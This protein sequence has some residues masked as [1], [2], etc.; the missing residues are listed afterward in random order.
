M[1]HVTSSVTELPVS[2]KSAAE[3]AAAFLKAEDSY[4]ELSESGR[5][6]LTSLEKELSKETGTPVALIAYR[7]S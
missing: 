4:A 5:K 2:C 6:K 7:L 3:H 1:A